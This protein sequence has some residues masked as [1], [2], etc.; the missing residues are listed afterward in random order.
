[1]GYLVESFY[2]DFFLFTKNTALTAAFEVGHLRLDT[3][4]RFPLLDNV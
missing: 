1:M 3:L 4:R 2:D